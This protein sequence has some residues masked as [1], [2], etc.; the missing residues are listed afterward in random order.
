[1]ENIWEHAHSP[2]D[3]SSLLLLFTPIF[4][5]VESW[6]IQ[7][8]FGCLYRYVVFVLILFRRCVC[9]VEALFIHLFLRLFILREFHA[10]FAQ[11]SAEMLLTQA[12][13]LIMACVVG[14]IHTHKY[15]CAQ[16]NSVVGVGFVKKLLL[17]VLA[18]ALRL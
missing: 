6:S 9:L 13:Y 16:G 18:A 2:Q 12:F 14:V 5:I 7:P 4:A 8:S 11:L 10:C 3:C 1:M 15:K 17:E